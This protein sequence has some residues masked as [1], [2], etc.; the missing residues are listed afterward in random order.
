MKTKD[1][2]H[3]EVLR[4]CIQHKC[5]SLNISMGSGKT[6]L[7]LKR[8]A[9]LPNDGKVLV[10]VPVKGL[11]ETWKKEANENGFGY[12]L[13][14]MSFDI[15][16]NLH[17]LDSSLFDMVVF[18]EIHKLKESHRDFVEG[19]NMILGL[20]GTAP[21]E[22]SDA[23]IL[24]DHFAPFIFD[25][26]LDDAIADG[27]VNDY[28][29][30]VHAIP[31]SE[32]KT[33]ERKNTKTGASFFVSESNDYRYRCGVISTIEKEKED[34]WR[35]NP[36]G[37]STKSKQLD[38]QLMRLR[39]ARLSAI[40]GYPGKMAFVQKL[41]PLIGDR[42]VV[43]ANTKAQAD[44]VCPHAHYSGNKH[45]DGNTALFNTGG[46]G[47]LSCVEQL[48]IGVNLVNAKNGVIMHLYSGNSDKG[49]QRMG[50]L[51]RLNPE[52]TCNLHVVCYKST[53]DEGWVKDSLADLDQTK[54][55]W[56]YH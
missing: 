8:I 3:E 39:I 22:T 13:D 51:L 9:Q 33:I 24:I 55:E 52:D 56:I 45:S 2:L 41:L 26:M 46:I 21:K 34:G 15:Y 19:C 37:F 38:K 14:D 30:T 6:R 40:K 29:I 54:I 18:D 32:E 35:S 4:E 42:T 31:L 17:K 44:K 7:T 43:F 5:C 50:R 53:V 36:Q 12:L 28:R 27:M 11:I 25:Y 20:T 10:I 47:V 23:R 48:S 16:R 49:R 1:E